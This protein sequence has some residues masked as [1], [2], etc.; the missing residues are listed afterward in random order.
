MGLSAWLR[1]RAAIVPLIVT[2]PGGTCTRLAVERV[3]RENGWRAAQNPAEANLVIIAGTVA[4]DFEAYVQRLLDAVPEPYAQ[5]EIVQGNDIDAKVTAAIR[6]MRLTHLTGH[7]VSDES[8]EQDDGTHPPSGNDVDSRHHEPAEGSH[9]MAQDAPGPTDEVH[10][11]DHASLQSAE[12]EAPQDSSVATPGDDSGGQSA[13]HAHEHR[14]HQHDH[15]MGRPAAGHSHHDSESHHQ[16]P[17]DP[18]EHHGDEHTGNADHGDHDGHADHIAEGGASASDMGM[19]HGGSDHEHHHGGHEHHGH[20]MGMELPGGLA[21][22]DRAPDRD[23]LMLDVLTLPLGPILTS[24]P[25]GLALT[26]RV[27]GDVLGE[28]TVSLLDPQA[29]TDPFWVR[30]WLRASRGERVTGGDGERFSA[31]GRLDSAARLLAVAGWD[32]QAAVASRLRDELLNGQPPDDFEARRH[33]WARQVAGSAV[34]G[35]SL[36]RVGYIAAG[37]AVPAEVTGDA[38]TRL[39]RWIHD[40]AEADLNDETPLE[41]GEY[42][43][44]G[45]ACAQWIVDNLPDLLRGTELSEARLIVASLDP[46]VELLIS[47]SNSAGVVHD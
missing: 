18:H 25:T 5:V 43:A 31:A 22:A 41:P 20:D 12:A 32:D 28:V 33:R 34:L 21:M 27:Q 40:I 37:S 23:G 47:S 14:P 30:P 35:W 38:H 24:W 11:A 36:R 1:R 17:T 46:D 13:H 42:L 4:P 16:M 9:G 29:H 45:V 10:H 39:L 15:D 6:R 26:T 19:G 3:V 7:A 8:G 44:D 2:A